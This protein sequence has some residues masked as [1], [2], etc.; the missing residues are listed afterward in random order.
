MKFWFYSLCVFTLVISGCK[1]GTNT[2]D[3]GPMESDTV[4]ETEIVTDSSDFGPEVTNIPSLWK[5]EL[6]DDQTE[7]LKKP[8]QESNIMAPQEMV[9]AMN[10]SYPEIHLDLKKISHDT[11]FIAI[12]ESQ[13]LSQQIGSTGAYNYMATAV[14]NLTEL[15]NIKYVHFDFKEGD[16]AAPGTYNRDD[17]KRLR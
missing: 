10:A 2:A 4:T 11:A 12:P 1:C 13:Y 16:H 14:Y 17:F 8:E 7:K 5:V 9:N 3:N 15:K 6:Q